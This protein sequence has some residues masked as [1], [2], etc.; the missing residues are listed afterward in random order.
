MSNQATDLELRIRTAL[1]GIEKVTG[2]RIELSKT[3]ET[4]AGLTDSARKLD[5]ALEGL[6]DL[7]Q[8][9][10][11]YRSLQVRLNEV[12]TALEAARDKQRGLSN[13]IAGSFGPSQRQLSAQSQAN[14]EVAKAESLLERARENQRALS[15]E[16]A[17][18][19]G[20]SKQQLAEQQRANEAVT[21][22]AALLAQ[23]REQQRALS[24]EVAAS[25]GP[26]KQQTAEKANATAAV[27]KLEA[28]LNK[29]REQQRDYT[30]QVIAADAPNGRLLQ[31]QAESTSRLEALERKLQLAKQRQQEANEAVTA[32]A[33]PNAEL[34][35][36]HQAATTQLESLS[37]ALTATKQRQQ[38]ANEAVAAG[39]EPSATLIK[40]HETA[41]ARLEALERAL[42]MARQ[43]QTEANAAV[44]AGS[45]PT[46][47]QIKNH[48]RATDEVEGL[49]AQLKHLQAELQREAAA[50]AAAGVQT[51]QLNTATQRISETFAEVQAKAKAFADAQANLKLIPHEQLKR[52]AQALKDSYAVLQSSGK[53]TA[54]ELAQANLRLQEGLI[55]LE[56][57][58]NGWKDALVSAKFEIGA[59]IAAFAPIAYSIKQASDFESALAGVRK[60]VDGSDE[61]FDALTGRIR[62][63]SK[64]LPISAAGLA[65]IAAAGGQL[66]V[67]IDKLDQFVVLAAKV[68]TAF[69][70]SAEE[71]GLAVAKLANVFDLPLAGV[72]RLGDSLNVLGNTTA[73]TE[74]QLLQFLVRV[75]GSAK[76]FGISAESTAALGAALI[77]L[78]KPP[79]IA[80]NAVNKLLTVLQTAN[81]Q[82]PKAQAALDAIGLSASDLAAR[83]RENPQA[84]LEQFLVTLEQ[85]DGQSRA[86]AIAQIL[87][88][89]YNDD[90]SLLVNSL[91]QYRGALASVNDEQKVAGSLQREAAKQAETTR[92][93][94]QLLKN[95]LGDIVLELGTAFLP[96]VKA[97]IAVGKSLAETIGDI[98]ELAPGLTALAATAASFG[99]ALGGLRLASAAA[100]VALSGMIGSLAG[101]T[102]SLSAYI[103]GAD[104]AAAATSR[105]GAA[106]SALFKVAGAGIAGKAIGDYLYDQFEVVRRSGLVVTQ[107]LILMAEEVR[108]AWEKTKAVFT[109]DTIEAAELRH[110]KR[111][112]KITELLQEQSRYAE[113]NGYNLKDG[114][115]RA[116]PAQEKLAAATAQTTA[117][118]VAFAGATEDATDS[119][120]KLSTAEIAE[121]LNVIRDSTIDL[122]HQLRAS[123]DEV[124]RLQGL[125]TALNAQDLPLGDLPAHLETAAAKSALLSARFATLSE[126]TEALRNEQFKKLG[127]DVGEVLT[128][129]NE[130]SLELLTAFKSL[131]GD[132]AVNPKL[133]TA[134]Y[135]ELLSTLESKEALTSLQESLQGVRIEGFETAKAVAAVEGKLAQVKDATKQLTLAQYDLAASADRRLEAE[136]AAAAG[137]VAA[138][139]ESAGAYD[140]LRQSIGSAGMLN[141]LELL[142]QSL[143]DA[144]TDGRVAGEQYQEL[145]DLLKSKHKELEEGLRG[146]SGFAQEIGQ[147]Y[148]AVN[149]QLQQLSDA[150][151]ALFT[152]METGVSPQLPGDEFDQLRGKIEEVNRQIALTSEY[153]LTYA[154]PGIGVLM[155]KSILHANQAQRAFYEQLLTAKQLQHQLETNDRALGA[156]VHTAEA[157]AGSF[158]LL[159]QEDLSGLR[160]AISDAKSRLDALRGSAEST[161]AGISDELDRLEGREADIVTRRRDRQRD[162]IEEQLAEA[163]RFG[164]R[165]SASSLEEAL[166]KLDRVRDIEVQNL[167]NEAPASD[168]ADR[169]KRSNDPAPVTQTIKTVRIDL[170]N[171]QRVNVLPGE[172]RVLEDFMRQ[173]AN[174]KGVSL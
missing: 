104:G 137:S 68:S 13:E 71:A 37:K 119:L 158:N 134:A 164:D 112:A 129:I 46:Q 167:R 110:Q 131:A 9:I 72:E 98:V 59:A 153:L 78:G 25:L 145:L 154:T 146:V 111:L 159:D 58:T 56:R 3:G 125:I 161:L 7:Q 45:E 41:T 156:N 26:S 14:A 48:E 118:V 79:E 85:L 80:A 108:T 155:E 73:A 1:E 24:A 91:G 162:E 120:D 4:A 117:Q 29:A 18:S 60:V 102:V 63:L 166:R 49:A 95:T 168:A 64:E 163:R 44:T 170:G 130:K 19:L 136:R 35:K 36:K 57:K 121:K 11:S 54:Q 8:Q 32:G 83:I 6:A 90:I 122:Q 33:E 128:G 61:Q 135:K 75:G 123:N 172:E 17:A 84:A 10:D 23:V 144:F 16:V 42:I 89:E 69:S 106:M 126:Q 39:S 53:L 22:T 150:T 12:A 171:G 147:Y 152:R 107:A 76:T 149:N 165:D 50:L 30:Q 99:V 138:A 105:L 67:P 81:V 52:E 113:K 82:S 70:I 21:Q 51:N 28:Q 103:K 27:V 133:L 86:E 157:L 96:T 141:D 173:L 140:Q 55:E 2:F 34:I 124:A 74:A 174:A 115:E 31:K 101:T 43:R 5:T 142:R 66:G 148:A 62:E 143:N 47:Q 20:P 94:Y 109:D 87:G 92:A 100:Q 77:S 40:R 93:Q 114:A 160:S 97:G 139:E 38:E 116:A 15:A 65:E 169:A 132:P 151:L 88:I 127:I